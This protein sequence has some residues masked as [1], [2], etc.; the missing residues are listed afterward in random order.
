[1]ARALLYR[2]L[3]VYLLLAGGSAAL[4][5]QLYQDGPAALGLPPCPFHAL[6]GH[7]CPFCGGQ[8]ALQAIL[9]GEWPAAWHWNPVLVVAVACGSPLALA[10]ALRAC[11]QRGQAGPEREAPAPYG[12]LK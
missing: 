5:G 4:L 7:S 3:T 1:M 6:T 11:R 10:G 2:R 12:G 8:H 9:R